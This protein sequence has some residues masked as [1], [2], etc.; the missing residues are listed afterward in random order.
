MKML[1][2]II[3]TLSMHTS[4]A[5]QTIASNLPTTLDSQ[6]HANMSELHA[7]VDALSCQELGGVCQNP[8]SVCE[9]PGGGL[10]YCINDVFGCTCL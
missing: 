1:A 9:R 5:H 10:G 7:D 8:G 4:C 6:P 2:F 3:L